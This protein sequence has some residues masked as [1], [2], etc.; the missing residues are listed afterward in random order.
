MQASDW[1]LVHSFLLVATHGSLSA[2]AR[3]SG[4]SQP[5]LSRHIRELEEQLG[6]SLF[7]RTASG[8]TLSPTGADLADH[9]RNMAQ[10]ADALVLAA[11]GRSEALA[12]TV[13][14]TASVNVARF[15]LPPIL[16]D[17]MREEPEIEIELVASDSSE[18]LLLREAD[19]A[20]RMYRPSQA[21][22]IT[23]HVGSFEVGAYAAP[24][25]LERRGEP[26]TIEEL[27]THDLVGYD[28]QHMSINGFRSAGY[29]VTRSSFRFRCDDEDVQWRMVVNGFGIGFTPRHLGD[30]EARVKR[31]LTGV[32]L[33][34]LP[35]WLTA[36]AELRT[37]RRVR[38]VYDFLAD[39]LK[40]D[41]CGDQPGKAG[42][43]LSET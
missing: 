20:L 19:I 30:R 23:R 37:S 39:R 41:L 13:R 35:L 31:I 32:T 1:N 5:T 6:I 2:A 18:N 24:A 16:A 38:R 3:Q 29:T 27:L 22:V 33:R 42:K 26:L 15:T 10:S 21:D 40:R 43:L 25:Y 17:L 4:R 36:H 12:G 9:A 28:R 14:I 34:R 7:D 8:L 11:H